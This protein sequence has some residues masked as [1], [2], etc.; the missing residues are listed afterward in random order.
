[1]HAVVHH[2][3]SCELAEFRI[4]IRGERLLKLLASALE[5]LGQLLHARG[6]LVG[7]NLELARDLR[8]LVALGSRQTQRNASG[9]CLDAPRASC[10]GSLADQSEY[11]DVAGV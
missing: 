9:H 8:Q 4:E 1:M 11:T 5:F 3:T 7:R 10:D 2:D 6:S